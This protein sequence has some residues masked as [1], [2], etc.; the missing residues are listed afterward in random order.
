MVL[1][2][3]VTARP[4]FGNDWLANKIYCLE[5][6]FLTQHFL[7]SLLKIFFLRWQ[8][9]VVHLYCTPQRHFFSFFYRTFKNISIWNSV[10]LSQAVTVLSCTQPC[11]WH[12]A[13]EYL[14]I[15]GGEKNIVT[16][17][18]GVWNCSNIFIPVPFPFTLTLPRMKNTIMP[19]YCAAVIV[20]CFM[21][22]RIHFLL[23]LSSFTQG[24]ILLCISI[25]Q[26]FKTQAGLSL[27]LLTWPKMW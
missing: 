13:V 11:V 20:D 3:S 6:L 9:A 21:S 17:L 15:F 4:S 22:V 23:N 16:H 24:H 5:N 8:R 7:Q 25:P 2:S 1:C 18:L 12:V 14:D 27:W 10:P 19:L 26:L